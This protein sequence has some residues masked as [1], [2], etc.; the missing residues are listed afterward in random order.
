MEVISELFPEEE[1]SGLRKAASRAFDSACRYANT[2]LGEK[3][4]VQLYD[5]LEC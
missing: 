3:E 4:V 5:Q 2:F 1:L